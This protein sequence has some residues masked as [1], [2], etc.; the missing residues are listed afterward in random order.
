MILRPRGA[1]GSAS[2]SASEKTTGFLIRSNRPLDCL[3]QQESTPKKKALVAAKRAASGR[4]LAAGP[5][6]QR[7][8]LPYNR[9][10][11]SRKQRKRYRQRMAAATASHSQNAPKT[12]GGWGA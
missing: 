8:E 1:S 10:M 12:Q 6:A 2:G 9:G 7:V 4:F 3:T 5:K 11:A